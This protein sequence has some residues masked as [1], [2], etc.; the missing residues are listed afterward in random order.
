MAPQNRRILVT[1]A[2]PYANGPLHL[3]HILEFTQTDIWVRYQ[4]LKGNTCYYICA[5]D[6]HGTATMLKAEEQGLTPE[7]HVNKIKAS[8]VASCDNFLINFDNFYSTHSEENRL[9]SEEIYNKLH[10]KGHIQKKTIKQLFDTE[11][12]L[13]LADRFIKGTCP[14]CKTPDQYGDNCEACGTT[15]TPA[16]LINPVSALSGSTPV[17]K[18]SEHYFFKLEDFTDFLQEWTTSGHLQEP[19]SNKLQEWLETGLQSW[20]I[21]RDA[22]YFGFN[23]PGTDDKYFYV[24][25]DAP[26][27]YMASFKNFCDNKN[28][29]FNQFWAKDSTAELYHFI[30]KDIINFHAL[31]WPAMLS[32]SNYR[33]P[34]GVFAHGFVTVNGQKMSKSRGTFINADDY[35]K[36]FDPEHLRYYYA[37]K[38]TSQVDDIDLNLEDFL[39]KVNT[40]IVNKLVNIASR[41]AKFITKGNNGM[42]AS[43]LDNPALFDDAAAQQST[44]DEHYE[45]REYAKAIRLIMK[46]ADDANK[47]IDEKAPWALAKEPDK[48]DDVIAICTTGLN[49][50]RLLITYLTPVLPEMAKA[51]EAFFN[52]STNWSDLTPLLDHQIN[53]FKPLAKRIEQKQIDALLA[54]SPANEEKPKKKKDKKAQAEPPSE[55]GIDQFLAVDLRVAKIIDAN[56]VEGADKLL[57][58]KLDV[59]NLGERQVFSGIKSSYSPEALIG[60]HTVLV[61]NLKPRKMRFGV[62]EGMILAAGNKDIYLLSPDDG[63]KPGDKVS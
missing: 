50:F 20:D 8:Q 12:G 5:S 13:F 7:D 36:H 31:F 18:D 32:A 22:P 61:A 28:M 11:K 23:I 26:I 57:A 52:K 48:S 58:L 29:D 4:K 25:L 10:A 55:I 49:L 30:G 6:A 62:S 46:L 38:L 47:Y 59:G 37:S 51:A 54:P 16:D 63:A 45:N 53:H 17:E 14:K 21:S 40:D 33:T 24:W 3:G 9:F 44:I 56:A 34:T 60:K 2:L 42:L 19:V 27:G 43:T 39:G 15:Y 41:C 35:L 1:S